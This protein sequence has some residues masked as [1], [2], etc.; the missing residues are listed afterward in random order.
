MVG[1]REEFC[2]SQVSTVAFGIA[3]FLG[4]GKGKTEAA[5]ASDRRLQEADQNSV[6]VEYTAEVPE[7]E[8]ASTLE[9]SLSGDSGGLQ[10]SINNAMEESGYDP[11][12]V[13]SVTAEAQAAGE[14]TA[15]TGEQ[16]AAATAPPHTEAQPILLHPSAESQPVQPV[17][18]NPQ[19]QPLA[20]PS[21]PQLPSHNHFNH[22]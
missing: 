20:V 6:N 15:P 12:E 11:V 21:P 18:R 19:I 7:G 4:L 1:N 2:E 22:R 17:Q 8:D 3:S 9:S 13:Q 10:T 16:T 5:C 14:N